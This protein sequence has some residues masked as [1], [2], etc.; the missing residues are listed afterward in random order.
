MAGLIHKKSDEGEVK[1][2]QIVGESDQKTVTPMMA[3]ELQEGHFH[4][5]PLEVA[6]GVA[7]LEES[8]EIG[9]PDVITQT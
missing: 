3:E 1:E 5:G 9:V 4:P 6:R 2:S 8:V 7:V